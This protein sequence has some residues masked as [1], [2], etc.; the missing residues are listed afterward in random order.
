MNLIQSRHLQTTISCASGAKINLCCIALIDYPTRLRETHW[1]FR[2]L[3]LVKNIDLTM[4]KSPFCTGPCQI[5]HWQALSLTLDWSH[6][7]HVDFIDVFYLWPIW[8]WAQL[9][10]DWNL[11]RSIAW[12]DICFV[13][14]TFLIDESTKEPYEF[15]I[16]P[17]LIGS[18][19]AWSI[20]LWQLARLLDQVYPEWPVRI[21]FHT[22]VLI[23]AF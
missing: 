14:F 8:Q 16:S 12:V 17:N 4:Q 23:N 3:P 1:A 6:I 2:W 20:A 10:F 19:L 5:S 22:F 18:K 15:L 9:L 11:A 7:E 21:W 13:C